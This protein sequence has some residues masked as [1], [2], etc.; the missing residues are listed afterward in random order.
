M[1]REEK[2]ERMARIAGLP[3][4]AEDLIQL[5]GATPEIAGRLLLKVKAAIDQAVGEVAQRP[6]TSPTCH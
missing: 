6:P 1:E 3:D 2:I 5:P 4:L